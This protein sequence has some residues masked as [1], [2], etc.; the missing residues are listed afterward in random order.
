MN[1]KEITYA[2]VEGYVDYERGVYVVTNDPDNVIQ[3]YKKTEKTDVLGENI[4]D[5][6]KKYTPSLIKKLSTE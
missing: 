2:N 3:T 1:K 6:I 4:L 5:I